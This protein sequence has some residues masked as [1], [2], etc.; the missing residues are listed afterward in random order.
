LGTLTIR[1]DDE[2]IKELDHLAK[3]NHKDRATEARKIF[4]EGLIIAKLELALKIYRKGSSI[5]KAEEKAQINL[6]DLIE[7]LPRVGHVKSV[8][9]EDLKQ[10]LMNELSKE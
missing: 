9:V 2:L 3:L 1:T 4:Q 8:N 6:W 5:G 10:E 7:Y